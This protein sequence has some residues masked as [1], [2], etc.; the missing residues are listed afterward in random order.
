MK[1]ESI[2]TV[3]FD[4]DGTLLPMDQ[5]VFTK[6]YFKDLTVKMIPHGYEA[7]S[8]VRAIWAGTGKMVGNVGE[9]TNEKA[10]WETFASIY[11]EKG[12][13]DKPVFDEFYENEFD[14]AKRCCGYNEK[15]AELVKALKEAGYRIIL[16]SN[17]IFPLVAQKKRMQWAG[18]DPD[19]FAY[20]TSYENSTYCKPNVDYYRE[21]LRKTDV[22]PEECLMIGN[23][24]SEDMV[25]AELGIQ[26]FLLTDC[27]INKDNLDI[28]CFE[29]GDYA[30]LMEALLP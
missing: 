24:V 21:I 23:D 30:V 25:A 16:A 13:A 2:K 8:L 11:G 1:K 28:D 22:K 29:H 14:A 3:L 20:I 6:T 7:E 18:I 4:L 27:M 12:L 17:P 9:K 19:D 5:D 26:T 15:A 10:F